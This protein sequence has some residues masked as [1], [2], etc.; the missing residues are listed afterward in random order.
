MVPSLVQHWIC[1]SHHSDCLGVH[2]LLYHQVL[3][4]GWRWFHLRYPIIDGWP[5][6]WISPINVLGF[7]RML[8]WTRHTFQQM[9]CC[10]VSFCFFFPSPVFCWFWHCLQPYIPSETK[11]ITLIFC[12]QIYTWHRMCRFTR[13]VF[14]DGS[15]RIIHYIQC[16]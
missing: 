2:N 8:G 4:R 13:V 6:S 7:W 16:M 10:C 5:W 3:Y 15:S 9:I 12:I 1:Y 11:L 14:R